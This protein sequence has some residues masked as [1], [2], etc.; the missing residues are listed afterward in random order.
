MDELQD[1]A[2]G[3]ERD[4][5]EAQAQHD[6][7]SFAQ[8]DV[9]RAHSQSAARVHS[10]GEEVRGSGLQARATQGRGARY[11][12]VSV[13][14]ARGKHDGARDRKSTRLNSSHVAISYAVFCLKKKN[15]KAGEYKRL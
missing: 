2:R 9:R 6:D 5:P 7:G 10:P 13:R 4:G 8:R 1:P 3:R 12:C 15:S 14:G 11:R